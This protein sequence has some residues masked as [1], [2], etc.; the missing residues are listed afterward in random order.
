MEMK[1]RFN[2][3]RNMVSALLQLLLLLIMTQLC[4]GDADSRAPWQWSGTKTSS[5]HTRDQKWIDENINW[6]TTVFGPDGSLPAVEKAWH[7]ATQPKSCHD[8]VR[9]VALQCHEGIV[10]VSA[11]PS[12]PYLFHHH[13]HLPSNR[14]QDVPSS[15]IAAVIPSNDDD[16]SNINS[17][18]TETKVSIIK[19]VFNSS[20][21]WRGTNHLK[22]NDDDDDK[23][24]HA[25]VSLSS[26]SSSDT[27]MTFQRL[28][29]QLWGVTGGR[30]LDT[31]V[32]NV[33]WHQLAAREQWQPPHGSSS[34]F[35]SWNNEYDERYGTTSI[36][37]GTMAPR[38]ARL[39]ADVFQQTTQQQQS[40]SPPLLP[41]QCLVWEQPSE[42]DR[43][44][45]PRLWR[46]DGPTGQFYACYCAVL[47]SQRV[48]ERLIQLIHDEGTK[49]N[50]TNTKTVSIQYPST[51]HHYV[52][53]NEMKKQIHS[54]SISKALRV[55]LSVLV[56]NESNDDKL[57]PTFDRVSFP[58]T[59]LHAVI[60]SISDAKRIQW[61]G[62]TELRHIL[63]TNT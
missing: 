59:H 9:V 15:Q 20:L 45:Q 13:A 53:L 5:I 33:L 56:Q 60:M 2:H 41:V 57:D 21:L 63:R 14:H 26:S 42:F 51:S 7:S 46:I 48:E 23:D 31:R 29:Q 4:D 16:S 62:D 28:D 6:P 40:Q 10:I 32:T 19:D 39:F 18:S 61:I 35:M 27:P 43:L 36:Q 12:S 22:D 11:T 58:P 8:N 54:W 25:P 17:N 34:V 55:A 1:E 37:Y 38:M 24:D 3:N 44:H 30:W 49:A 47:G 52:I 50:E